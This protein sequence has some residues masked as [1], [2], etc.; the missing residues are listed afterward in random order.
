MKYIVRHYSH[1][2]VAELV[3]QKGDIGY[4]KL[5]KIYSKYSPGSIH[6]SSKGNVSYS[7]RSTN[8]YVGDIV[9]K[10]MNT[11]RQM[12]AQ[13]SVSKTPY[14]SQTKTSIIIK[15]LIFLFIAIFFIVMINAI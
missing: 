3:N 4:F 13:E 6:V 10:D 12:T 7:S 8:N 15:L 14:E 2:Y 11:V 9:K 1:T 5:L